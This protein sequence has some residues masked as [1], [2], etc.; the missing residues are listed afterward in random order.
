MSNR[1]LIELNHDLGPTCLEESH[2]FGERLDD[3]LR[4]GDKD[5]LPRCATLIA[6]RHHSEPEPILVTREQLEAIQ[7][8][9]E[10]GDGYDGCPTGSTENSP[11]DCKPARHSD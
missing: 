2:L 6:M 4:S 7:W 3:Y 10:T 8:G 9:L 1:S 11:T 5:M